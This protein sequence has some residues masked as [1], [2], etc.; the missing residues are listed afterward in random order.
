MDVD[1]PLLTSYTSDRMTV[2]KPSPPSYNTII[3]HQLSLT[4]EAMTGV[5][6]LSKLPSYRRCFASRF[7]P[8]KRPISKKTDERDRLFVSTR[9]IIRIHTL[10]FSIFLQEHDF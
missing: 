4:H 10:T 6:D 8:Y 9:I 7:H 1:E 3:T 2:D 5:R